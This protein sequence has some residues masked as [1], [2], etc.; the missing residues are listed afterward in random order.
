MHAPVKESAAPA[1]AGETAVSEFAVTGMNCNN[2]ARHVTEAIQKVPGV[3]SADV[4]LEEGRATV[5][6]QSG[7]GAQLENVVRAVKEAG[8]EAEP[9]RESTSHAEPSDSSPVAAWKFTVIFGAVL[10]LPLIIGEWIFGW[11]TLDWF[12]WVGFAF[13]A[14]VMLV[15]S[16]SF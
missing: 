3:T 11:G 6:W 13:S 7:A 9:V 4:R 16:A 12:K 8:Y 2:C 14:P 10:T 5:R 1:P 15:C